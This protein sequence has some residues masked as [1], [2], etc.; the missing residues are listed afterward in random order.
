MVGA[1]FK[2][3]NALVLDVQGGKG[4][5]S[6]EIHRNDAMTCKRTPLPIDDMRTPSDMITT[7]Q[8]FVSH[9]RKRYCTYAIFSRKQ[10]SIKGPSNLLEVPHPKGT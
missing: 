5:P 2:L 1:D 4:T 7:A 8:R 6:L 10:T 3:K 9:H